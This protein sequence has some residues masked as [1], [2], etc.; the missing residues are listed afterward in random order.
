MSDENYW[1]M[2]AS[3]DF[4]HLQDHVHGFGFHPHHAMLEPIVKVHVVNFIQASGRGDNGAS[5]GQHTYLKSPIPWFLAG[6]DLGAAACL[7]TR[8]KSHCESPRCENRAPL[9][10]GSFSVAMPFTIMVDCNLSLLQAGVEPYILPKIIL[11]SK[12]RGN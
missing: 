2:H 8:L 11:L 4:L 1:C 5:L 10:L 12:W 6:V 7:V 9:V 3:F